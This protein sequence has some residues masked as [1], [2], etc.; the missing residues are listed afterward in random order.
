MRKQVV[1]F[2][3][4][5]TCFGAELA[6]LAKFTET[7]S[8]LQI[9]A[10]CVPRQPWTVAGEHGALF[11][12]QNGKFEAWQ[13]PVKLFSNFAIRA[14]LADYPVP[15]DVNAIAAEIKVT[16]A[17][18]TITYSHPDFTICQHMFAP[19]GQAPVPAGS[20]VVFEISS[21]RPLEIT[22]SFTPEML[23][24]WPAPNSGRPNGEWVKDAN[25]GAYILH[26]DDPKFSAVV[27]MPGTRPGIMVPYQEHPQTFPLELKLSFDPKRDSGKEYPLLM[28]L[29]STEPAL[30]QL[31]AINSAVPSLYRDTHS[32]YSQLQARTLSI[33]TPDSRLNEALRWAEVSIDQAQV[34]YQDETGLVAGYYE[35]A[36]S[37]RPG[38]AWFFGR[39]TLWSTYAI[40]SYGDFALTRRALDFI[41]KRQREDGKIMHEFS[42]S[43]EALDWKSTPYFYAAADA[44]PLLVMAMGDYV[45]TSGDVEYLRSN[46]EA[47]KKAYNFTRAHESA[48][49]VFNN[50][51]GTGW[52]ESWPQG[53]PYQEIYLAALDVQS[54]RAMSTLASAMGDKSLA[55]TARSKADAIAAR[56]E[57]E[58]YEPASK[59]YAFSLN[60]N[61]AKDSTA[62]IYPSVAWW[63]GTF[64]LASSGP[65]LTR[66]ASPEFSADWGTRDISNK[67]PFYDPISYHQGSIWPL[68][69]GWTSVAEYRAGRSLS[70]Y[71]HLMQNVNL[72][73]AQD[74]GAVTELLSGDYFQPL[75]R[76]SSHQLW[77]SAMVISP[78]LRGLF[79]LSWDAPARTLRVAPHL[80]ANWDSA[81]IQNVPLGSARID[82]QFRRQGDTLIIDGH[83]QNDT[84]FCLQS[85][86][87]DSKACH[88]SKSQTLRI[89][90]PPVEVAVPVNLPEQGATTSQLKVIDQSY[91]DR[92][93]SFTFEAEG[94]RNY[95]LPLRLNRAGITT[96]DAFISGGL[97][98]LQ[99]QNG[100][101]FQKKTVVFSW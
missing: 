86:T 96:S 13:W 61:G 60:K 11:G 100:A 34:K 39:D 87:A 15:I 17:E 89:A 10:P 71:A 67:M 30:T 50:T 29:G 73:W 22:F 101:S 92:Q 91:T 53:M 80:P 99:M 94:G 6:P 44:A 56:I 51:Q 84:S 33:E 14:E 68:F 69:T 75:G 58:Y 25:S 45:R 90:L 81:R 82:L 98:H 88:S 35:S 85:Q 70:G 32:D 55:A 2:L 4:A 52:V 93:A 77:S 48:D 37:A 27:G 83:S 20:A 63:D 16:P 64:S 38:Y 12:R 26:T 40:N 43:A 9:V 46:W 76:S 66:W 24:M 78:I 95:L 3:L 8:G 42:Q 7:Q 62:S 5:A 47:V 1:S 57:S 72:T 23:R 41:I 79:G 31:A 97:L 65:M 19:R 36:D 28:A 54:S 49:G 21:A 74:L 59:F 18:T